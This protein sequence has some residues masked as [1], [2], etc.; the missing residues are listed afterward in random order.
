MLEDW[1]KSHPKDWWDRKVEEFQEIE[2][3]KKIA[4]K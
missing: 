4:K 3:E 1:R 2:R